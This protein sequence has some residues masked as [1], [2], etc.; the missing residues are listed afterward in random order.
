MKSLDELLRSLDGPNVSELHLVSGK[1]PTARAG[2]SEQTIDE[3]TRSSDDVLTM[4]MALGGSRYVEDLG[5]TPKKWTARVASFGSVTVT[6]SQKGDT[7]EARLAVLQRD[8]KRPEPK[9]EMKAEPKPEQ[10]PEVHGFIPLV[11]ESP[12]V[13]PPKIEP[14]RIAPPPRVEPPRFEQS[15]IE[16][17][18]IEAPRIEPPKIDS[19]PPSRRPTKSRKS[20][21][22]MPKPSLSRIPKVTANEA[23]DGEA[24]LDAL[25]AAART[26]N[27][28]DLHVIGER[29]ALLRIAGELTP[30]GTVLTRGVVDAMLMPRV[31]ARLMP[32]FL[33]EGSV[34]FSYET[35]AHGRFRVNVGRHLN[36]LKASLRLIT[37]ELP[38]V[39]ALGLPPGIAAATAHH[40]GLVLFTG[41]TGHGK[42]TSLTAIVD[43]LNRTRSQ[44]IISV[45]DPIEHLHPKKKSFISQR[46]VGTH[47]QSFAAA[48]KGS[49]RQD[50]DVIVVGEL[51]DLDT[52]RIAIAASET[53]HL[54]LGTMST[55]SASKTIDRL[56]DLF[57][58]ADQQQI[59]LT[60][61]AALR[62]VVSQR[63]VP[64]ADKKRVHAAI[65]LLPSSSPLAALIRDNKTFQIPSL[66]QRGKALGIVRLDESLAELVV[67]KKVSLDEA[68][69][70]AES[71]TELEALVLR[72]GR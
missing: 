69:N 22:A 15:R 70:Y 39:E 49:L 48:L 55:P 17:P 33:A 68:K 72:G 51:R 24:K 47:T 45:E 2:D 9:I 61:A 58:P 37:S 16:P 10:K 32:R 67:Q 40:Q 23:R 26:A 54:V 1:K 5:S 56:I 12:R 21:S 8:A 3:A 43:L 38:T 27:A 36:G 13:E 30:H 18:R 62:L 25:L 65:E 53:G 63:L 66:Q 28:S 50:P 34:D 41:P 11:S 31:P 59:R 46:E 57:P 60:L 35:S 7:I 20:M 29:P 71:A 14:P 52:V 42:T 19:P 64:S 4:L 6:A 44:H